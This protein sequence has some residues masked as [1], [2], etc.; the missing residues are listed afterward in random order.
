MLFA[1]IDPWAFV[2]I[3]IIQRVG[4]GHLFGFFFP[5]SPKNMEGGGN[6]K[7]HSL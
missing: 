6:L 7:L 5:K 4:D 1:L 3:I 2:K